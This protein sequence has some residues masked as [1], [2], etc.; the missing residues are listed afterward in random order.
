MTTS[1]IWASSWPFSPWARPL[2]LLPFFSI[3]TKPSALWSGSPV[4]LAIGSA[5][6]RQSVPHR[7]HLREDHNEWWCETVSLARSDTP[8]LWSARRLGAPDGPHR[9]DSGQLLGPGE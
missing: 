5:E 3:A 8:G 9:Q 1:G 7:Y 2:S 4:R 6:Y